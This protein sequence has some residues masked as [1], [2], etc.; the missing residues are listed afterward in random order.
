LA[1]IRS[2]V[3][4]ALSGRGRPLLR[5]GICGLM[6]TA[7]GIGHTIPFLIPDFYVATGV[8][9]VVV[10]IELIVIAYIRNHYMDTT[11][12][13]AIF[14]VVLGGVLVFLAGM[15]IGSF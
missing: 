2:A 7:G 12:L 1:Q 5:G 9:V 14:Q 15:L 4:T 10:A 6:T 3:Q 11:L 13:T 8:A